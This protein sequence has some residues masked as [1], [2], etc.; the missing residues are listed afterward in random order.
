MAPTDEIV[1]EVAYED[2]GYKVER[3]RGRQVAG[4]RKDEREIEILEK[5]DL[6][7]FVYCP[8]HEGCDRAKQ[9]KKDE[10]VVELTVREQTLWSDDTPL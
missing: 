3:C 8:L 9:E 2:P 1:K 4:A 5:I 6:E 10:T 7:L